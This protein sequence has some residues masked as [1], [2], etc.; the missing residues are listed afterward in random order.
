MVLFRLW[1]CAHYHNGVKKKTEAVFAGNSLSY[2]E[3]KY[4]T[5]VLSFIIPR[6]VCLRDPPVGD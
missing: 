1:E 5:K 6:T 3:K 4:V 2:Q